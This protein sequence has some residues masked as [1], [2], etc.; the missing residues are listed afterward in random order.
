MEGGDDDGNGSEGAVDE[1]EEFGQFGDGGAPNED[2]V[3]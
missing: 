3:F 1:D 2:E